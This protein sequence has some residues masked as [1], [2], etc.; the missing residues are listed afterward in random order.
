MAKKSFFEKMGLV[1][2]VENDTRKPYSPPVIED[3]EE[4]LPPPPV[5]VNG[6]DI[7]H[8]VEDAYRE[9]GME[10]VSRSIYKVGEILKTLPKTIPVDTKRATVVAILSTFGLTVEDMSRDAESRLALIKQTCNQMCNTEA[11]ESKRLEH[12]IE[13]LYKSAEIKKQQ[14]QK[15]D[16]ALQ[17]ITG[18]A[19]A[20]LA[21]I[22]DLLDF[23]TSEPEEKEEG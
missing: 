14:M 2:K 9:N 16:E 22:S 11:D 7:D 4:E 5:K 13:E 8:L 3:D 1:E 10:D 12:E 17:K 23:I 20:E 19:Q 18:T 21:G 15:H 6:I